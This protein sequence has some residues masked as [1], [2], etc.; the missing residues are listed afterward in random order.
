MLVIYPQPQYESKNN[1]ILLIQRRANSSKTAK[2]PVKLQNEINNTSSID[3]VNYNA[4]W[5]LIL[6][7][8][9]ENTF[10]YEI[11]DIHWH[12]KLTLIMS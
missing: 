4:Q 12:L 3:I 11:T 10:L 9:S 1:H 8:R 2:T 5:R 7:A 6:D